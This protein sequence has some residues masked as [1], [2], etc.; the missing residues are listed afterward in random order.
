MHIVP[1]IPQAVP[2]PSL[3]GL[4]FLTFEVWRM[5]RLTA[6]MARARVRGDDEAADRWRTRAER[7]IAD[8]DRAQAWARPRGPPRRKR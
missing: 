3:L 8:L 1:S 2:V 6:G 5:R 4:A 7:A